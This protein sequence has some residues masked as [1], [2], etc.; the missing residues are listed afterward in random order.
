MALEEARC[1]PVSFA[2]VHNLAAP[3]LIVTVEDEITGTG[4][5]VHRLIFGVTEK[6]GG[7][8]V[9]HDWQLLQVLNINFSKA[10]PGSTTADVEAGIMVEHLKKAF[11]ADLSSYAPTLNRPISWSEMLLIP[12]QP[13]HG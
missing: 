13:A 10:F 2:R 12:M 6:E 11:D 4:S 8:E 1:L 9:L 7:V 3:L 5:L